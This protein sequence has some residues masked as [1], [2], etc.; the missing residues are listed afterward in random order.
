MAVANSVIVQNKPYAELSLSTK[1]TIFGVLI[2]LFAL[3]SYMIYTQGTEYA[4]GAEFYT[5]SAKKG[6]LVFQEYNCISCHQIYGL[7]GYMG[8]DL[9]NVMSAQGKG[10]SF[11]EAFIKS[12][13]AKMPK[14][15]MTDEELTSLLDYLEYVG[16]AGD[17][18]MTEVETTWYGNTD[19]NAE[20]E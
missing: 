6:K 15:D 8:P 11:A 1:R 18:P 7:G 3:H 10:R 5:E 20:H 12:G 13:T 19:L 2:I 17:Y 4:T 14:F 9:T 16:K